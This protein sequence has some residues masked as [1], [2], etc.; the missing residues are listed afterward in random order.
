MRTKISELADTGNRITVRP[1]FEDR[2]IRLPFTFV[3]RFYL[4]ERYEIAINGRSENRA[5]C[6]VFSSGVDLVKSILSS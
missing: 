4:G 6:V 1:N 2:F 5:V 3:S